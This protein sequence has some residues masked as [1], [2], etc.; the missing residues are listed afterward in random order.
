MT[1]YSPH[2]V[3]DM[4][5]VSYHAVL[6][7]IHRGDLQAERVFNRLQISAEAL[8]AYRAANRVVAHPAVH[9]PVS[10]A[11]VRSARQAGS[12]AGSRARLRAIEGRP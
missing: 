9:V 1:F 11:R 6:R 3:A 4:F 8:D 10:Q 2:D 5:G 7:A 12:Q